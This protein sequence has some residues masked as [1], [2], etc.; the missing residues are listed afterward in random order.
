MAKSTTAPAKS[1]AVKPRPDY[2]LTPHRNGCWCKKIRS[3]KYPKGKLI[4]FGPLT[5]PQAALNLW[6]REKDELLA[7]HDS[8]EVRS[9]D[10]SVSAGLTV[11]DAIDAYL[12]TKE[13]HAEAGQITRLHFGDLLALGKWLAAE[14]GA[15]RSV[16]SLRPDDFGQLRVALSKRYGPAALLRR[17]T[18]V[19]SIFK[20]A[21]DNELIARPVRYG[22]MF[23]P[24]TKKDLRLQL[25][26]ASR[27]DCSPR[28]I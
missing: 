6:L 28:P 19:R 11:K 25:A 17:M 4:Y 2:P 9:R 14:I 5:D 7:G 26:Q 21:I 12:D 10:R 20:F 15:T 1:K 27:S 13:K 24:P 18:G 23:A 8:A 22:T 16:E 3:D